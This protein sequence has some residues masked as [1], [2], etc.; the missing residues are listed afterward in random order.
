MRR[1]GKTSLL[2]AFHKRYRQPGRADA[3]TVYLSLAEGRAAL[4]DQNREVGSVLLNTISHALSKPNFSA[5]DHNRELGQRLQSRFGPDRRAVRR[6][7]DECR[8]PE[9]LADS[10][11]LLGERLLE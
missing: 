1:I 11:T 5:A 9:S 2:F 6:A 4:M 7:M 10:L 8:D 3:I